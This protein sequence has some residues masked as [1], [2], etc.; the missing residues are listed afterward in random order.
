MTSIMAV[1]RRRG[2]FLA[3]CPCNALA[4][5]ASVRPRHVQPAACQLRLRTGARRTFIE[6]TDSLTRTPTGRKP[7]LAPDKKRGASKV[8]KD[9]DEAVK[10]IKSGSTILSAGFGLCG[11]A[12][13]SIGQ[14]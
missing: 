11:V 4:A 1:V 14:L 6:T 9:A 3:E 13:K 7:G 2:V 12:G 8:Y 10:D 5:F